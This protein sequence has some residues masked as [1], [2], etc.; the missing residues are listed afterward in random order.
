MNTTSKD[1]VSCNFKYISIWF[2]SVDAFEYVS[3]CSLISVSFMLPLWGHCQRT[4]FVEFSF[5]DF[6]VCFRME[7]N[8]GLSGLLG[9]VQFVL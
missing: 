2:V 4:V 6:Q 8:A 1:A 3:L 9:R 7:K 5:S